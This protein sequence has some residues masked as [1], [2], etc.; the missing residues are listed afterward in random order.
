MSSVRLDSSHTSHLRSGSAALLGYIV[1]ASAQSVGAIAGG[2][3]L[4]AVY[5]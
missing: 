1:I 5:V 2:I 4:Y 3:I